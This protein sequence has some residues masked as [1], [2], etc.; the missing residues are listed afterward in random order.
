[1]EMS[2][3]YFHVFACAHMFMF[4]NFIKKNTKFI[5]KIMHIS[6]KDAQRNKDVKNEYQLTGT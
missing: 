5:K 6:S 2:S 3:A 4:K 1:M